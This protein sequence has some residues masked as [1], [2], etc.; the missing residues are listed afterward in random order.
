M[1]TTG[2][3]SIRNDMNE[4][5][6]QSSSEK[7]FEKNLKKELK[8]GKPKKQALAIAYDIKKKNENMNEQKL[9]EK[10]SSS[11]PDWLKAELSKKQRNGGKLENS[12]LLLR[13]IVGEHEPRFSGGRYHADPRTAQQKS[14]RIWKNRPEKVLDLA[15]ANFISGPVPTSSKDERLKDP[16]IPFF[17][18]VYERKAYKGNALNI[19]VKH[20]EQVYAKGL[21]DSE[22]FNINPPELYSYTNRGSGNKQ[23]KYLSLKTI[24]PYVVDF[25]HIDSSDPNN[26]VEEKR[27]E[28]AE[29][30]EADLKDKNLRTIGQYPEYEYISG[31]YQTDPN[32]K[33]TY[34]PGHYD[35]SAA[36]ISWI[37]NKDTDKSGYRVK[38]IDNINRDLIN[39]LVDLRQ[40]K[41]VDSLEEL[42]DSLESV[43]SALIEALSRIQIK[44]LDRED[45]DMS[46]VYDQFRAF[47]EVRKQ[48][49]EILS[50]LEEAKEDDKKALFRN[51]DSNPT[52]LV[53]AI[54]AVMGGSNDS[55]WYSY[56]T[57]PNVMK[58]TKQIMQKLDTLKQV[59]L[60][61]DENLNISDALY[62]LKSIN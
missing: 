48:Y 18:V 31:H 54:K 24:L 58:A 12:S 44:R 53:D 7:A 57:I 32:G 3:K 56:Y 2:E 27:A 51:P 22:V 1:E 5:L 28:R 33:E 49:N 39:R 21:N 30:R 38:R 10:F 45:R 25:C 61:I 15:N 41:Y 29:R 14:E 60:D 8:A 34:I 20:F 42:H 43:R 17:H 11:M 46:I 23:F 50:D 9:D 36:G 55:T 40:S 37:T 59:D 13:A 16:Y 52:Y 35:K 26:Y 19:P 47:E 62:K 6:I 4:K